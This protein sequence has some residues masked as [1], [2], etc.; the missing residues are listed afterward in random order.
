VEA[1]AEGLPDDPDSRA[2]FPRLKRFDALRPATIIIHGTALTPTELGEAADAG[3]QLVWSPQSNLRLYRQ[4]TNIRAAIDARLPVCLG[5]D[6]MPSG[7]TSLL[8]EMKVAANQ[9]RAQGLDVLPHVLVDMVTAT[10]ADVAG[11]GDNLGRLKP[12]RPADLVVLS[13]LADDAYDSV[14]LTDPRDV[15]MVLIGGD[16]TYARQDWINELAPDGAG[17]NLSP[18][19]AWG[20]R[21]LLDNGYRL[22]R[23]G[24]E[25]PTLDDLR[26]D[27]IKAFPQVG[28]IWA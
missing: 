13:R 18:V 12:G 3:A 9:M 24:P 20:R 4:T 19:I 23:G 21:M 28:P 8:A 14:L 26:A 17:P 10:A 6:W 7:S 27:L 15:D 2:E 1:V 11:L 25:V 22:H 16:I 5:A